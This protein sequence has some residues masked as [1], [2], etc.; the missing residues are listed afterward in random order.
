MQKVIVYENHRGLL[1]QNGKFIKVLD[2]GKYYTMGDSEVAI[3]GIYGELVC[4][5]APVERLLENEDFA[6]RVQVIDVSDEQIALVYMNGNFATALRSGKHL[7]WND[8]G[9]YTYRLVDITTPEMPGDLSPALLQRLHIQHKVCQGFE[10]TEYQ[11]GL[12]FIDRK[13]IRLL[14]P[15]V[16]YFWNGGSAVSVRTVDTRLLQLD[17]TGQEMLTKD[18]VTIRVNLVCHYRIREYDRILLEVD[19]Y[20]EQLH[21]AAQM[22]LREYI[23]RYGLDEI[24]ENK[25]RMGAYLL[26]RLK[27]KEGDLYLTITDAGV[28]DIILPGEIREIMNTVLVAEKRAQANVITRREEVASTRS[29]LNTARLMD[30]NQTLY[31]LKELEYLEKICE[32][33]GSIHLGG[34]GDVLSQLSALLKGNAS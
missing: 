28:K 7:Y 24:L 21:L 23:G 1:F 15:G 12:L 33:V 11:K 30:E 13:F 5:K 9:R 3:T 32:H 14:E 2:P 34:S 27:E 22:A 20:E 31:K 26:E 4:L 17:I 10:V 19:D 16:H 29:L 8:D 25:D 6:S 18:K